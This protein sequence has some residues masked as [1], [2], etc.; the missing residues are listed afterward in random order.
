MGFFADRTSRTLPQIVRAG[1]FC[2]NIL[3]HRDSELCR[4]FADKAAD[5]FKDLRWAPS[6]T[7]SPVLEQAST[8]IDCTLYSEVELGDHV[9]IVGQ[10]QSLGVERVYAPLVFHAARLTSVLGTS[11]SQSASDL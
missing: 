7:G 2:A 3:G 8:W 11:A 1:V 4:R 10:V 5:R 6:G 9:L